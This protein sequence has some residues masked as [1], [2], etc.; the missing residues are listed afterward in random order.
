MKSEWRFAL[1]WPLL[2]LCAALTIAPWFGAEIVSPAAL[3]DPAEADIFLRFRLSRTLLGLLAG[4]SFSIAGCLFQALLRNPLA[5]PYTLG[6]STG[7]ALGAVIAIVLD[8]AWVW[9]GSVTGALLAL[10]LI[11]SVFLG[12]RSITATGLILAGVSVNSVC[13][14]MIILLQ[15]AAGFSKSFAVT[16]W[17]IGALDAFTPKSIAVYAAVCLPL[18]GWIIA[19]APDWD[20]LSMGEAWAAGRGVPVRT[21]LWQACL[22]GSLLTAAT[23]SLTGPV[24]F[25]GLMVPHIVRR[26]SGASHRRLLPACF[27]SGAAF[28]IC[29]DAVARTA[30]RPAEIPVGVLTAILG[31]P[32]LIWILRG[33]RSEV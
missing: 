20:L 1:G 7:A 9:T 17:L 18:M 4:A 10:A 21:L 24:P 23:V 28:L 11:A 29:C 33:S 2:S 30:V 15:S 16:T 19:K 25:V 26:Y 27:F 8:V 5:S 12:K 31:G 3:R 6:V 14:A 32:G 22:A 13:S